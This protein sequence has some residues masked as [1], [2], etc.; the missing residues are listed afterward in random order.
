MLVY[1]M[2]V[3][4]SEEI[5]LVEH[6]AFNKLSS[7]MEEENKSPVLRGKKPSRS[8]FAGRFFNEKG[9]S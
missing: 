9:T 3:L 1:C 7:V 5:L 6:R 8:V 2:P 4:K